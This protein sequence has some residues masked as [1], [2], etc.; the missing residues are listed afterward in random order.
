MFIGRRKPYTETGIARLKCQ[1]CGSKAEHQWQVCAN[2]NRYL[3]I[4]IDCDI[5][6]NRLALRFM[7]IPN[8]GELMTKYIESIDKVV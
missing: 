4:C 1:R 6:L 5:E 2:D 3:P 8:A 7:R